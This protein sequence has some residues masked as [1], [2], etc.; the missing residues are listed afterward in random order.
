MVFNPRIERALSTPR[1]QTYRAIA[2]GDEHAFALY[3][4]NGE[5]TAAVMPMIADLEVALR[6]TMHDQL[7]AYFGRPDWWASEKL[8]LDRDKHQNLS[9]TVEKH[10][11]KIVSGKL[12]AGKVVADL[13]FGTWVMLLS[14]GGNSALG[15]AVDYET[16]LWRPALRRGFATTTGPRPRRPSRDAVHSRA[17][18]VQRLRNRCAHHEP[19]F[20]GVKVPGSNMSISLADVWHEGVEL[21]GWVCPDLADEHRS[22]QLLRAVLDCRP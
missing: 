21:L 9:Q 15:Q 10:Q 7:A 4:W 5:L 3:R 12:T 19:V 17:A 20:G 18:L 14:R 8:L 13:M 11:R 1:F 22:A 6:N 2:S 16:R